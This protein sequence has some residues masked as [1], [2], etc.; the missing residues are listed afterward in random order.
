MQ[1]TAAP[2]SI[3]GGLRRPPAGVPAVDD[4]AVNGTCTE[5]PLKAALQ[6]DIALRHMDIA[7]AVA[8]SF[9]TTGPEASDI[10]QVAYL[11]L[12]KAVQRFN[13]ARGVPFASFAVPTITGEIK[14][15]LRDSCWVVRPP[16]DVQDL[17]TE[18]AR[19]A[20]AMAQRLGR[21]ATARE[22][23]IELGWPEDKVL[24]A[25]A[26]HWSLRPD[27]LDAPFEGRSWADTLAADSS[28]MER[29]DDMISLRGAVN[30][31]DA[32]EKELLYRRY[33]MEQT[34]QAIG[35]ELGMSQMQVSRMLARILV[36]LQKRLLGAP[37]QQDQRGLRTSIA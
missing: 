11:G 9:A 25:Q 33:F 7:E 8:R 21:E 36:K 31:L 1:S 29:S 4:R 2:Q 37:A 23:G 17:R 10:R 34:Q 14:R 22:L 30:E 18:I 27:S 12:I 6:D 20:P 16:R 3:I 15:Y 32:S 19:T 26:S 13:P 24:E 5:G 28:G 35:D